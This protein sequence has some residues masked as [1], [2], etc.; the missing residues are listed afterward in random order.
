MITFDKNSIQFPLRVLFNYSFKFRYYNFLNEKLKNYVFAN[1]L[2]GQDK[3]RRQ[4]SDYDESM[5]NYDYSEVSRNYHTVYTPF[6]DDRKY[7]TV[8]QRV[9]FVDSSINS[10]NILDSVIFD[11]EN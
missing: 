3:I 8:L 11:A 4:I 5:V 1:S 9:H 10:N 2:K 7:D 6:I